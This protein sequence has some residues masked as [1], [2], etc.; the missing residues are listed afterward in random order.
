MK[1]IETKK[2][3]KDGVIETKKYLEHII[4]HRDQNP[5]KRGVLTFDDYNYT[6]YN[7]EILPDM[8]ELMDDETSSVSAMPKSQIEE[9]EGES[10][11]EKDREKQPLVKQP[12]TG[13]INQESIEEEDEDPFTL[14]ELKEIQR[15][16]QEDLFNEVLDMKNEARLE[17]LTLKPLYSLREQIEDPD[18]PSSIN[19]K[20]TVLSNSK[21]VIEQEIGLGNPNQSKFGNELCVEDVS[22]AEDSVRRDFDPNL[23][24]SSQ[25]QKV[26]NSY[27]HLIKDQNGTE[28][29]YTDN[30]DYN[31]T[32]RPLTTNVAENPRK[33]S[34]CLPQSYKLSVTKSKSLVPNVLAKEAPVHK[35]AKRSKTNRHRSGKNIKMVKHIRK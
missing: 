12:T 5:F 2:Y 27:A 13:I 21:K 10:E 25:F 20:S 7:K 4:T 8:D 24:M 32:Q 30:D 28:N 35:L 34:V 16:Q 22:S 26:D 14:E 31:D 19:G 15:S 23:D 9:A 17:S 18:P 1:D 3:A 33:S 6:Y 29:E 11:E